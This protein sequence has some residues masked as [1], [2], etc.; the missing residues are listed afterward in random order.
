MRILAL[1]VGKSKSVA[2]EVDT[3]TGEC[4]F[5][6]V[7]TRPAELLVALIDQAHRFR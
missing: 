7:V 1:D 5:T 3:R 4:G 6:K 2:Y